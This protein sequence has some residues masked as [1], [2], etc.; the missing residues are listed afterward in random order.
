MARKLLLQLFLLALPFITY[1]IYARLARR[2]A[3]KGGTWTGA[4]W[5]W[6]TASG[7]GLSIAGAV[8]LAVGFGGSPGDAYVSATMKDGAVVPG[9][10]K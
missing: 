10:F 2:A 9:H 8:V 5:F 3:A 7:L 4:P 6:L 1:Y